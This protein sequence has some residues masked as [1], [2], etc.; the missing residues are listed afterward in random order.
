[1]KNNIVRSLDKLST[2]NTLKKLSF[3][4]ILTVLYL[5]AVY[6][7]NP[8]Y[9]LNIFSNIIKPIM[10]IIT[11]LWGFKY[12]IIIVI[13]ES[14]INAININKTISINSYSIGSLISLVSN[15]VIVIAISSFRSLHYRSKNEIT[16]RQTLANELKKYQNQLEC[17]VKSKTVELEQTY[18]KLRHVEKMEAL[19]Q[20][21]GGIAHDFNNQLTCIIG[22]A[23]LFKQ[24]FKD[25]EVYNDYVDIIFRSCKAT[26]DLTK[27]L[28]AFARKGKD[29][30][31]S[32]D[33]HKIIKE[34][35]SILS[36]SIDKRIVIRERLY[37]KSNVVDGD[38]GQLQNALLNLAI[39][40]RDAMKN[41]GTLTIETEVVDLDNVF[42]NN[43]IFKIK[44]GK[45]I[46]ISVADTGTGIKKDIEK[47]IF[48]PFFTTKD[49]DKGTGMGLAAVYGTIENHNGAIEF[50]S[51]IDVGTT[52][53]IYLPLSYR[54]VN[55]KT[56]EIVL[57]P[58]VSTDKHIL[59]VDDEL[60]ILTF[61]KEMLENTGYKVTL[62][63]SGH[64]AIH[65]Y[66]K[67]WKNIDVVIVDM[68]MPDLNGAQTYYSLKK[69]NEKVKTLVMTGFAI[70]K[71]INDAIKNGA[72]GILKKPFRRL[73]LLKQVEKAL[74]D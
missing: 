61:I 32:L 4:F 74:I 68:I 37:A 13:M 46:K 49:R 54:K 1:M 38:P 19:G 50:T 26:S 63:N 8:K 34:A 40:A 9:P 41:S 6:F 66:S 7:F 21:A 71:E 11:W 60:E 58:N 73:H 2:I 10:I 35:I 20:L 27:Q 45:F 55:D 30:S 70:D 56:D 39:N 29:E 3:V 43:S 25:D 5:T 17:L 59:V 12:G 48:E 69:I 22:Y 47:H 57:S 51:K 72:L 31:L 33:I 18:E 36:R 65:Y 42:C 28:L 67:Y 62:C 23:E 52:F 14:I 15:I 16:E 64:E 53:F 44:P 24:K